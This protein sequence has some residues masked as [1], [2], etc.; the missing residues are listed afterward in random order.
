MSC[1]PTFHVAIRRGKCPPDRSTFAGGGC[2]VDPD[3]AAVE[4]DDLAAQGQADA[5]PW[6]GLARVQALE[7]HEYPLGVSRGDADAVVAAGERPDP[8][9]LLSR[10]PDH[11]VLV[12]APELDRVG[13]QVL[14]QLGQQGL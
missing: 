5:G 11:R 7:D 9:T 10:D 6:I 14:E 3:V 1:G 2:R 4:V 13:D 12:K 8:V